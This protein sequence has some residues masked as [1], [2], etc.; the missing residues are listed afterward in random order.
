[1]AKS[2]KCPVFGLDLERRIDHHIGMHVW[3]ETC[4]ETPIL[5]IRNLGLTLETILDRFFDKIQ[6]SVIIHIFC[7]HLHGW[8]VE[9]SKLNIVVGDDFG[10]KTCLGTFQVAKVDDFSLL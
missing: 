2:G 4:S 9:Y 5:S 3:L 7:T 10:P 8:N 6:K 1:M